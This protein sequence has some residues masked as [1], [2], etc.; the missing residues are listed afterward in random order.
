MANVDGVDLTLPND[1]VFEFR[2]NI[3]LDVEQSANWLLSGGGSSIDFAKGLYDDLGGGSVIKTPLASGYLGHGGTRIFEVGAD[4]WTGETGNFGAAAND[5]S[6]MEKLA[7]LEN[8]LATEAID[9]RDPATLE[10]GPYSSTTSRYDPIPVVPIQVT[11]SINFEES[12]SSFR[13]RISLAEAVD[14]SEILDGSGGASAAYRLTPAGA[15]TPRV[16]IPADTLNAGR[17]A[18]EQQ[19]GWVAAA[20]SLLDSNDSGSDQTTLPTKISAGRVTL[21]GAWRGSEAAAIANTFKT[22]F[23]TNTGTETVDLEA[24]G[25]SS[26]NPLTG[27][28]VLGEQSSIDPLT[29]QVDGGVYGFTMDL[30]EA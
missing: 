26:P 15:S 25:R 24:P 2:G 28:Y 23:L 4:N 11:P 22:D 21:R 3:T 9:S 29:P 14:F 17:G 1:D 8:T 30:R 20:T 13:S 10:W 6:V 7:V 16:P 19:Q 12:A 18:A 5:D 27:T